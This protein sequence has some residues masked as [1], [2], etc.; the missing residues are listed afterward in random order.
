MGKLEQAV[1]RGKHPRIGDLD[2]VHRH[3]V[4][5]GRIAAA[6]TGQGHRIVPLQD[7]HIRYHHLIGCKAAPHEGPE[8]RTVQLHL[9]FVLEIREPQ[10]RDSQVAFSASSHA[11]HSE[12]VGRG[13]ASK[14]A[15][16]RKPGGV[17]PVHVI[18]ALSLADIELIRLP[19]QC[20][21]VGG[22]QGFRPRR[23]IQHG[24]PLRGSLP[25]RCKPVD[26]VIRVLAVI[27][28]HFPAVK[29]DVVPK[30]KPIV[31]TLVINVDR[32]LFSQVVHS[33]RA[34]GQSV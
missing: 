22:G 28:R 4:G 23:P 10:H 13:A 9:H 20:K 7:I 34:Q 26:I 18:L 29:L 2:I 25:V 8:H 30:I 31:S 17:P 33:Q 16:E 1:F 11:G 21:G 5:L 24:H 32:N 12:S 3:P 6:Q 27:G 15:S 19:A 14:L